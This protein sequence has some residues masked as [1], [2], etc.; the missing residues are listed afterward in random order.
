[1]I[2]MLFGDVLGGGAILFATRSL[3]SDSYSR[4]DERGADAFSIDVMRKLA[5]SPKAMGDLLMRIT[6]TQSDKMLTILSSH[7]LTEERLETM[8]KAEQAGNGA[9]LIPAN[10]WKALQGICR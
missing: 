10:E 1:M 5:R 3:L 4:D 9:E 6:G 8:A 7:P 2:G